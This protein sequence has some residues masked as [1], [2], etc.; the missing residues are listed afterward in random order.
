MECPPNNKEVTM[1]QYRSFPSPSYPTPDAKKMS[2]PR[3][4]HAGRARRQDFVPAHEQERREAEAKRIATEESQ[5]KALIEKPESQ[6]PSLSNASLSPPAWNASRQDS[7]ATLAKNWSS[8]DE[9][10]R[11]RDEAAREKT[12]A[13]KRTEAGIFIYRPNRGRPASGDSHMMSDEDG[14][15]APKAREDAEGWSQIEHKKPKA[16]RA[17]TDAELE[18]RFSEHNN[19]DDEDEHNGDLF[20]GHS[21]RQFY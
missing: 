8:S 20:D 4:Y 14:A 13:E 15:R 2:G 19:E 3:P 21:R 17:M 11:L 6:F 10:A 9:D 18:A 1:S 7:F 5:R 16:K 12:A